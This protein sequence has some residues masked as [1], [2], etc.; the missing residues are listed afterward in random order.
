VTHDANKADGIG[1]ILIVDDEPANVRLLERILSGAGY[2]DV[3][4][5]TDARQARSV[6]VELQPDLVLLDLHMPHL[7]GLAVMAELL[8]VVPPDAYVPIVMLTADATSG[9]KEQALS[10]GARDFLVKPFDRTEVLL[11]IRNLLVTRQLHID[12]QEHNR[13]LE[14]QLR[15]QAEQEALAAA[16]H[17]DRHDRVSA[18]LAG[19]GLT[20]VYQPIVE[21]DTSLVVGAEAL[22]RFAPE[23]YRSPDLWFADAVAVGLATRLEIAAV[24]A[25]TRR[26]DELPA[27]AYL[28]INV[29]P[30]TAQSAELAELMARLPAT[31]IVME[32]TEHERVSDYAG[33]AEALA[34]LRSAGVRVAVDDAGS[35][36]A[37]LEHILRLRPNVIKLDSVL[38]R[39]L[40]AD[41]VRRALAAAL[42]TFARDIGAVIVAEGIETSAELAILRG[43]GVTYGQ[44]FHLARP[45]DLPL[46]MTIGALASHAGRA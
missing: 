34:P 43:L 30:K 24:D 8:A 6:F 32:L 17:R 21:L 38:T 45:G 31:R 41:P 9:A 3:H 28:S 22:A 39:G 1:R 25:A 37:S 16:A 36:F 11:R 40:D 23:P 15:E 10:A 13:D 35:G 26:L 27:G 7:D 42:V 19:H 20:I 14:S 33:L 5:I 44:G 29:S 18:V 12:L 2:P 46:P 4:A